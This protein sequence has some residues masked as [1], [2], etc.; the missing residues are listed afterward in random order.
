MEWIFLLN[1][2]DQITSLSSFSLN[3]SCIFA[4]NRIW[5]LKGQYRHDQQDMGSKC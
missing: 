3:A 2:F 5:A 1:Q 4:K